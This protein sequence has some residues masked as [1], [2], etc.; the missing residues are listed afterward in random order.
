[1]IKAIK[2]CKK[3]VRNAGDLIK[4]EAK[5]SSNNY[6]DTEIFS[7]NFCGKEVFSLYAEIDSVCADYKLSYDNDCYSPHGW[8]QTVKTKNLHKLLKRKAEKQKKMI[9]RKVI[10]RYLGR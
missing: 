6:Y 8:Y 2:D 3:L 1:M 9:L 7:A 10:G 5:F 4:V